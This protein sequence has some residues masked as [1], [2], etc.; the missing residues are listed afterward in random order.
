MVALNLHIGRSLTGSAPAFDYYVDSVNGSDGSGLDYGTAF[1]LL[2][3][4]P[5]AQN[6]QGALVKGSSWTE[7]ISE[8]SID[9][10]TI[11]KAGSGALP[12]ISGADVITG[13]VA[14]ATEA[15]VWQAS[16]VHDG[17]DTNRGRVFED[18]V[19]LERVDD[20]ATC[21]STPGSFV[22]IKGSDGSPWTVM[23][24]TTDSSDPATKSIEV[25]TRNVAIQLGDNCTVTGVQVQRAINNNGA[26][27]LVNTT[28]A[29]LSHILAVDG[30]KHNI[31]IG[32]GTVTDCIAYK[33]DP[34][35]TY[36][37]AAE[38]FVS[39]MDDPTGEGYT[40]ERCG[41]VQPLQH[42]SSLTGAFYAHSADPA[43]LFVSGIV[44]QCWASGWVVVTYPAAGTNAGLVDAFHSEARNPGL[45]Y[46]ISRYCTGYWQPVVNS[47]AFADR[48]DL[49]SGGVV[50]NCAFAAREGYIHGY[51]VPLLALRTDAGGGTVVDTQ[52]S[53][54]SFVAIEEGATS[55]WGA[56]NATG[57]TFEYI[58]NVAYGFGQL[59]ELPAGVTYV[60]NFNVFYSDN[61]LA[62]GQYCKNDYHGGGLTTLA[63][64]QAATGQDPSS[65]FLK[66]ED[67]EIGNS[68]AFWLAQAEAVAPD[69]L[70]TV[71]P[72]VGD[73]RI[74]PN[75]RVY[76]G[77]GTAYIG[78]FPDG[79]TAITECGAQEH[80]DWNTRDTSDGPP[81]AFPAVPATLADCQ[82]YC[83]NPHAWDFYP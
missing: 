80:W 72:G 33:F 43:D 30:T 10:L 59:L 23:I 40:Y 56:T 6:L 41:A 31:G 17:A 15:N 61:S 83:A 11:A 1:R 20:A 55:C 65:V 73:F 12:I 28:G 82:S 22:D 29:A 8:S 49:G 64:W 14:H 39:Y 2:S 79:T 18:D 47:S 71:G 37:N 36:E 76:G 21:G 48:A 51:F 38:M 67:Q 81:T 74:N 63:A 60:G 34:P 58:Y 70:M 69:T 53:Y 3:S 54:S 27:D 50:I 16:V 35:T 19:L 68:Y 7:S 45:G 42:S 5:W 66:A 78:T 75:A 13:W 77:D 25:T 46:G 52:V 4:V 57:G 24:H 62:A 9:S 26:I 32:A 44:R